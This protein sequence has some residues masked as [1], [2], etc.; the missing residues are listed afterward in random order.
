MRFTSIIT[1]LAVALLL[2]GCDALPFMGAGDDNP[3]TFNELDA[4]EQR[5]YLE[6]NIEIT[7]IVSDTTIIRSNVEIRG[8]H[9]DLNAV[10]R[11]DVVIG[12]DEIGPCPWQ[13]FV[14]AIE[15]DGTRTL[16]FAELSEVCNRIG[17]YIHWSPGETL[18]YFDNIWVS[19]NKF[20]D[21]SE[22]QTF[23]LRVVLAL[24]RINNGPKTNEIVIGQFT[25]E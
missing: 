10:N 5:N 1:I 18:P 15:P 24:D 6:S 14:Y 22:S 21:G 25:M 20:W 23:E 12:P 8:V 2:V 7:G 17:S 16:E 11:G 3:V 13:W 4:D 19:A 9:A